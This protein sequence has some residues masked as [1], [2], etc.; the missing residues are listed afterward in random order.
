MDKNRRGGMILTDL[1]YSNKLIIL[2][3]NINLVCGNRG[4]YNVRRNF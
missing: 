4:I 3:L 2:F 1:L